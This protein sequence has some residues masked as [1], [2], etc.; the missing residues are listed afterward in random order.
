MHRSSAFVAAFTPVPV[1]QEE[2]E[3]D[4]DDEMEEDEKDEEGP[5]EEPQE[6]AQ[7]NAAATHP[8]S[9]PTSPSKSPEQP[10]PAPAELEPESSDTST[11]VTQPVEAAAALGDAMEGVEVLHSAA[12]TGEAASPPHDHDEGP[13][14]DRAATVPE[15]PSSEAAG[16]LDTPPEL[17]VQPA[18]PVSVPTLSMLS[19]VDLTMRP[20]LSVPTELVL[21]ASKPANKH[22][23]A[24]VT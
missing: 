22:A 14:G 23:P 11:V 15:P 1:K 3:E 21:P 19:G 6:E 7:E 10:G 9:P 12:P 16:S 4:D 5:Q 13:T 24:L 18:K 2:V 20:R 8:T 17:P